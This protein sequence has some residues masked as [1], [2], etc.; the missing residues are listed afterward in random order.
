MEGDA[1]RV[2]KRGYILIIS[3]RNDHRSLLI[4]F[5]FLIQEFDQEKKSRGIMI[6]KMREDCWAQRPEELHHLLDVHTLWFLLWMRT[7]CV[8][9]SEN[10]EKHF[11]R[12]KSSFDEMVIIS[13]VS[14]IYSRLRKILRGNVT[15]SRDVQNYNLRLDIIVPFIRRR[16][17]NRQW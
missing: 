10:T 17:Q 4:F 6:T 12:S 13:Q 15:F 7:I 5:F 11:V 2:A 14:V 9:L 3:G 16:G 8:C 1:F